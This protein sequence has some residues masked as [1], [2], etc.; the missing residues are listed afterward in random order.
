MLWLK[1][2]PRCGGDLGQETDVYGSYVSCLQ[3]GRYLT[4]A[5][6]VTLRFYARRRPEERSRKANMKGPV[7]VRVVAEGTISLLHTSGSGISANRC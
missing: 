6:E 1:A 5:E 2:C 7:V 4:E 3:C